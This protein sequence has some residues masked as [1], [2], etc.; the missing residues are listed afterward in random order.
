M[1]D[2]GR[3]GNSKV[4]YR[5]FDR[6]IETLK[7]DIG[8]T[9]KFLLDNISNA[10]V[11]LLKQTENVEKRTNANASLVKEQTAKDVLIV[12]EQERSIRTEMNI[13]INHINDDI[14]I[15]RDRIS[16]EVGARS[17]KREDY[18][19]SRDSTARYI[20]IIAVGL[21][22]LDIILRLIGR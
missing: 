3:D 14:R 9:E 21:A 8:K 4:S 22:A 2:N 10:R 17:Q 13:Q 12:Q 6:A 7:D 18:Q 16:G 20:G 5:E 1:S 15:L 11:D 19:S